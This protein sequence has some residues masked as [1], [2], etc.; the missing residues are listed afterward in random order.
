[1]FES[2]LIGTPKHRPFKRLSKPPKGYGG[3]LEFSQELTSLVLAPVA[4]A[5]VA[6]RTQQGAMSRDIIDGF[7]VLLNAHG[8]ESSVQDI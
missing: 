3:T 4:D 2:I 6:A 5:E 1:M 7:L 8:V